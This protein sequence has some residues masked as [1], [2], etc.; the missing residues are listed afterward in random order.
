VILSG[1]AIATALNDA[2]VMYEIDEFYLAAAETLE[3]VN[4]VKRLKAIREQHLEGDYN[5][6]E[7]YL[8]VK[9]ARDGMAAGNISGA[10]RAWGD[11]RH[12]V[13]EVD[14]LRSRRFRAL[15]AD[16]ANGRPQWPR[17]PC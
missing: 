15:Y 14:G 9:K 13:Q 11:P 8:Q 16:I 3:P 10:F 6:I 2:A 1:E 7:Q 5:V 4:A 17:T 12:Q